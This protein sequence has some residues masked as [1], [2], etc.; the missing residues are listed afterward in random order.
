MMAYQNSFSSHVSSTY[1]D[2]SSLREA[3]TGED[4][5]GQVIVIFP[6]RSS[7]ADLVRTRRE[8]GQSG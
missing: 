5:L 4:R 2:S 1:P 3:T 8:V 7:S 6:Q